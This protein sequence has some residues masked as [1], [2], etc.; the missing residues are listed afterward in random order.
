[1]N[2]IATFLPSEICNTIMDYAGVT[3]H[4]KQRFSADVLTQI[5]NGWRW[6]G[7]GCDL[8]MWSGTCDC[9]YL[10]CCPN[11]FTYGT[12]NCRHTQW[13]Y[14]SYQDNILRNS[15]PDIMAQPYLPWE[16]FSYFHHG[17]LDS[18]RFINFVLFEN[19]LTTRMRQQYNA[20]QA[21][22]DNVAMIDE[23]LHGLAQYK[24]TSGEWKGNAHVLEDD[25]CDW[26]NPDF[27]MGHHGTFFRSKSWYGGAW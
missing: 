17:R 12:G 1:M 10:Q 11:C 4:W 19:Q 20:T 23:W 9:Q 15:H 14:V 24:R 25:E 21:A 13:E 16:V 7:I 26:F 6:V 2:Y 8:H 3:E 5:N 27:T 18:D 22:I